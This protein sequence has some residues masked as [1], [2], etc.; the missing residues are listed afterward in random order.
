MDFLRRRATFAK[1]LESTSSLTTSHYLRLMLMAIMEMIMGVAATSFTL[2]TA[3][4]DIRPW[5]GWADVHWN[6]SRV[7][8]YLAFEL[9]PF[10][11]RY[12]Y[13]LWWLPPAS[14][15]IFFAF[16]AF[17]KDAMREYGAFFSWF[18]VRLFRLRIQES[19]PI[20]S[21]KSLTS[22]IPSFVG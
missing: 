3:T 21:H 6:F 12:Y 8:Q 4:L 5:T 10:V 15:F 22:T 11:A 13:A 1:H 20:Q 16:F 19:R 18:R 14:S 17:G 9:S 2:W 7:D